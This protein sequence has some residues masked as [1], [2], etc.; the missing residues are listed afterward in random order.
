MVAIVTGGDSGIGR[1]VCIA[2]AREGCDVALVYHTNDQDAQDVKTYVEQAGRRCILLKGDVSSRDECRSFVQRTVQQLGKVDVLV[3]NAGIQ[4]DEPDIR[5]ITEERLNAVMGTNV[6]SCVWLIQAALEQGMGEGGC[7]INNSSI[8]AFKGNSSLLSYT[9]SK[10]AMQGLT[11]SMALNLADKKV[12]VNAVAPG[13]IWT[14]F[15]T[16]TWGPDSEKLQ[17]FG[18]GTLM[19][20]AGQPAEVGARMRDWRFVSHDR[21]GHHSPLLDCRGCR[22]CCH[23]HLLC[24]TCL[25]SLIDDAHPQVYPLSWSLS[26]SRHK[27]PY[28]CRCPQ[29]SCSSRAPTPPS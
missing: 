29:R 25:F 24:T 9:A 6:Y 22:A 27:S 19:K 10:G 28:V 18:E 14:P 16:G 5:E 7:I 11:R 2:Y 23:R 20:R 3:N 17:K 26:R 15:I 1:A 4:Y 12:R 21:D 13:P 8:N